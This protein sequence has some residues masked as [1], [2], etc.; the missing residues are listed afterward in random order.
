MTG[1]RNFGGGNQEELSFPSLVAD[2]KTYIPTPTTLLQA[3]VSVVNGIAK[4]DNIVKE[5]LG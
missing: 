4:L 1:F 2:G 5:V 3:G